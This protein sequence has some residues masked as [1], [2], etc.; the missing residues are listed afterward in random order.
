[1]GW[2][3]VK[4]ADS[5]GIDW[6]FGDGNLVN[7]IPGKHGSENEYCGDIPADI[8]DEAIARITSEYV[9]AWGRKPTK[10]E[11]LA[12]LNFCSGGDDAD[13]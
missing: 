11:L 12:T 9:R 13:E 4:D 8:M 1:M 3:K 10:A 7:A 5:G 2:W 6:G